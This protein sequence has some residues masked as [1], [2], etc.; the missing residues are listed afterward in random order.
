MGYK[1]RYEPE[2]KA[3]NLFLR[4]LVISAILCAVCFFSHLYWPQ[5]RQ[6]MREYLIPQSENHGASIEILILE[7]ENGVPPQDAI[8]VFCQELFHASP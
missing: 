6:F 8:A 2:K 4:K 3:S 5:G 7:L 1:I